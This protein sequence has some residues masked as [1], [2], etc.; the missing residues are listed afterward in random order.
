MEREEEWPT[1]PESVNEQLVPADGE[2][3]RTFTYVP[4]SRSATAALM[5]AVFNCCV[6][7]GLLAIA[8]VV[9][10]NGFI[11]SAIYV[12]V[13]LVFCLTCFSLMADANYHGNFATVRELAS[14]LYGKAFMWA[15]DLSALI[16]ILPITYISISS[17]YIRTSLIV[18]AKLT[19]LDSQTWVMAMKG[20]V[21]TCIILPLTLFR[22]VK[23]LSVI[24]FFTF[25]FV[26]VA[27]IGVTVRFVQWKATGDLEGIEH[28]APPI[29]WYPES[30]SKLPDTIS[31]FTMF[32]TLYSIHASVT[33]LQHDITGSP[34]ERRRV[35][36]LSVFM[37]LPMV[38]ILY[39]LVAIEGSLMLNRSCP[40]SSTD[41]TQQDC[42]L[43]NSN[44]LLSFKDDVAMTIV[45]LLY[46]VVIFTSFPMMLYPIRANIM[47]WFRITDATR[48]NYLYFV[49]IGFILTVFCATISILIPNIDKVLS[50]ITN[51]FGV[52][53]FELFPLF[54]AYKLPLLKMHSIGDRLQ[55]CIDEI[56]RADGLV[57][58][59]YI[60]KP[61][62]Y[63][64]VHQSDLNDDFHLSNSE[65]A[66]E[67]HTT[68]MPPR[69]CQRKPTIKGV[70][71]D[72][73]SVDLRKTA[74]KPKACTRAAFYTTATIL[75]AC[76]LAATVCEIYLL[77]VH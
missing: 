65:N 62:G 45:M 19:V 52:V 13:T 72:Y 18:L 10:T 12:G 59:H 70:R 66:R 68:P 11:I 33:P 51:L 1:L 30:I 49:L 20:I 15:V 53:I 76:N 58:D 24:S 44:I 26:I 37:I 4:S 74:F 46:S 63:E 25:A 23:A 75:V 56:R 42:I 35:I 48:C 16:S 60:L 34:K 43:I 5:F 67:E 22:T 69:R 27:C 57:G 2:A 64:I 29:P 39:A 6:G 3:D 17:D 73:S 31:Y 61:D 32:F 41:G 7:S 28:S 77:V 36:K 38:T 14:S 21:A 8:K 47:S 9:S 54:T 71:I 40:N 55:V 50:I